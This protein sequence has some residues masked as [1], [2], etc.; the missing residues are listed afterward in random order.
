MS[1]SVDEDN[2]NF[3]IDVIQKSSN[4]KNYNLNME[5]KGIILEKLK[6]LA[7]FVV[8][9]IPDEKRK[10]E[11]NESVSNGE[12]FNSFLFVRVVRHL[13]LEQ[14]VDK[15]DNKEALKVIQVLHD[16]LGNIYYYSK[17][18]IVI[19]QLYNYG[20]QL[21]ENY[22]YLNSSNEVLNRIAESATYLKDLGFDISVKNGEIDCSQML[23]QN[24]F[25]V[26]DRKVTCLG[27]HNLYR[28]VMKRFT[29]DKYIGLID[30]YLIT[31]TI[32]NEDR[33]EPINLLINLSA[34][35]FTTTK[36]F[37]NDI[38]K[39][40]FLDDIIKISESLLDILCVQGESSFEYA[41]MKI[42][43]LSYYIKKE[44]IFDKICI[45][46]QYSQQFIL[47]SMDYLIS[48][49]FEKA[50]LVYSYN[51]YRNVADCI[52]SLKS[53]YG[54]IDHQYL[55]DKTKIAKYKIKQILN[56]ISLKVID[57]NKNYNSLNATTN[58]FSRPLISLANGNFCF[59]D[60][61]FSGFGFYLAM[62]DLIKPNYNILDR[63][64][65]E[66]IEIFLKDEMIAKGYNCLSGKYND[67]NDLKG[68]DC[69]LILKSNQAIFFEIK[70]QSIMKEF[71]SLDDIPMYNTL[72]KG[73]VKAQIQAFSH[74]LYLQKNGFLDLDDG[75]CHLDKEEVVF[76][77]KKISICFSEYSFLTNKLFTKNLLKLILKGSITAVD[78][79][80]NRELD[81]INENGKQLKS[82][83]DKIKE[84]QSDTVQEIDIFHNSIFCSLQQILTAVWCCDSEEQFFEIVREWIIRSDKTLDAYIPICI[85][86]SW[87]L[88]PDEKSISRLTSEMLSHN[89]PN[90]MIIC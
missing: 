25:D 54:V 57:V 36:S 42:S 70:K 50:N 32:D 64:Q 22:E 38:Q 83:I 59:I 12:V 17:E 65:G 40:E 18:S 14:V 84:Y 66:S 51:E 60:Q 7:N 48:P 9:N 26:L 71:N 19:E 2:V 86:R 52:L 90:T 27:G 10:N 15:V 73:M 4:L 5:D 63:V 61:L 79:N 80:R 11:L 85:V 8:G 68:R 33:N 30:R 44:M 31:R 58:L 41:N 1:G 55:Y 34:R 75:R 53:K 87:Q 82:I 46:M 67:K 78:I 39:K 47:K 29:E 49:W 88:N 23:L 37:L 76:P 16:H 72:A 43:D 35:H 62:Y 24:I 21:S 6:K 28:E 45:P 56:D 77:S 3:I 74:E 20:L 81:L 13:Y 69:D 89:M